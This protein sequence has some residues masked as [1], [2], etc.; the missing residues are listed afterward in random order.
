[1]AL[2]IP[3]LKLN[4]LGMAFE[5][6]GHRIIIIEW[7]GLK[8]T[9]MIIWFQPPCYVQGC[10]PSSLAL[11]AS[12]DGASTASLGNLFRCITT[13]WVK[14]FLLI[15]NL[16]LHCLSLKY[17]GMNEGGVETLA[18]QVGTDKPR[19]SKTAELIFW[20]CPQKCPDF[21]HFARKNGKD[22]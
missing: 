15:S 20:Y 16:N 9:S 19:G 4:L 14:N 2:W 12:R 10:Q 13:L 22:L 7:P 8:R 18:N 1:M 17:R 21:S 11:N 3:G 5:H 6:V